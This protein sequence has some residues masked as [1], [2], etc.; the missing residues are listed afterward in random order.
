MVNT[1]LC[2]CGGEGMGMDGGLELSV[3]DGQSH[4]PL[5][6]GGDWFG[7]AECHAF[8]CSEVFDRMQNS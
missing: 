8:Q 5:R 1:E 4:K 2:V 3:E 7:V 6:V